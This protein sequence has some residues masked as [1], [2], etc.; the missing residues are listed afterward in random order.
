MM[1]GM[2]AV[3][4][5]ISVMLLSVFIARNA[6]ALGDKGRAP[7]KKVVELINRARSK[8]M[9]C[10]GRYYGPSR[11]LV[12]NEILGRASLK[13]C[14][15]MADKGILCHTSRHSGGTGEW[16]SRLGYNWQAYGEN[17]GEGYGTPEEVVRGW[18]ESP[19]HCRNIMNP[20]FKEAGCSYARGQRR[21]YWTL[22]LA[23]PATH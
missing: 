17:V 10:G 12:W 22:M 8:G 5:A 18:L 19:D 23:A 20:A 14:L 16:L 9:S 2:K 3:A 4:I 13:H 6:D 15:F 21:T 1:N 7:E 11:P